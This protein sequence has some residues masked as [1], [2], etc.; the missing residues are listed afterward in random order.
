MYWSLV[1]EDKMA[2]GSGVV[3]FPTHLWTHDQVG[4]GAWLGRGMSTVQSAHSADCAQCRVL[5][6]LVLLWCPSCF[7]VVPKCYPFSFQWSQ[8]V[9][10][11]S[12]VVSKWLPSFG[13]MVPSFGQMV[14]SGRY[15]RHN[16]ATR[17]VE[18]LPLILLQLL[19]CMLLLRTGVILKVLGHLLVAWL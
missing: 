2:K 12:Q 11:S 6:Q 17:C 13:Q 5:F 19:E 1:L 3:R 14:P 7:Q 9:T 8:V 10:K 18:W 4:R 16:V 15:L